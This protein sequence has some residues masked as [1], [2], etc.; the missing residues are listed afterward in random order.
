MNSVGQGPSPE[1]RHRIFTGEETLVPFS[2]SLMWFRHNRKWLFGLLLAGLVLSSFTIHFG[3]GNDD[4]KQA[5]KLIERFHDRMNTER[6]D[7]IYEDLHPAFRKLLTKEE[8]LQHMQE[9][10]KQYG[11]FKT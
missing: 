4:K 7:E 11:T 3:Y 2:L 5:L 8:W 10:R 9:N 6:F 1:S